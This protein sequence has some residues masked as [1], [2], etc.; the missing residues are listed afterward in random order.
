M[1][2]DL[3]LAH[4]ANGLHWEGFPEPLLRH[5]DHDWSFGALYRGTF[6]YDSEH[7]QLSL[8]F[9]AKSGYGVWRLLS[10]RFQYTALTARLT[11]GSAHFDRLASP[12]RPRQIWTDAP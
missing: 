9:S 7:D 1:R 5:W 11:R 3:F 8:W 12:G 4:S 2:D 10:A 6:L